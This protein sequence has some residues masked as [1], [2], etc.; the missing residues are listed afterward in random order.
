MVYFKN[1]I[2]QSKIEEDWGSIQRQKSFINFYDKLPFTSVLDDDTRT[3]LLEDALEEAQGF[4][5]KAGAFLKDYNTSLGK[6]LTETKANY[7]VIDFNG[8]AVMTTEAVSLLYVLQQVSVSAYNFVNDLD[9]T[10]GLFLFY[11]FPLYVQ[12]IK[13]IGS[14]AREE[15]IH[16][17][18]TS[19][20]FI[21]LSILVTLL[22]MLFYTT[23]FYPVNFF[24]QMQ[25]QKTLRLITT[26]PQEKLHAMIQE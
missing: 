9:S 2:K 21:E 16:Q 10:S 12:T 17:L 24:T 26:F 7:Y 5:E 3:G 8:S 20:E 18:K 11:N 13:K 6:Y 14:L 22:M 15:S 4:K 1:I 19:E 25:K 23:C